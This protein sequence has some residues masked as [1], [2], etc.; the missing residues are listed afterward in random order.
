MSQQQLYK[1]LDD[2]LSQKLTS[3]GITNLTDSSA[4]TISIVAQPPRAGR[5]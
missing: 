2:W 3:W 5:M 4:S 1:G